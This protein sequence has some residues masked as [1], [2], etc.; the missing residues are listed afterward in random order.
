[1][2]GVPLA[3]HKVTPH[4]VV[5]LRPSKGDASQPAI[6]GGIV[7]RWACFHLGVVQVASLAALQHLIGLALLTHPACLA[8]CARQ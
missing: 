8:E 2:A 3:A 6:A 7:H 4:D 1:M 5:E